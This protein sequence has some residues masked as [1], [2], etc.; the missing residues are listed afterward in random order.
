MVIENTLKQPYLGFLGTGICIIVSLAF[1]T[2]FDA[3]TF[4]TWV[5]LFL[6]SM[7][8]AQMVLGLVWGTSFP[9]AIG[10]MKQPAKGLS[11][12]F[13]MALSGLLVTPAALYLVGGGITPPT[14]Y[15]IMYIILSVV[16]TFWLVTI[17]QCWPLTAI[18][19]HSGVIGVGIWLFSYFVT[20]VLFELLFD[21]SFLKGTPLH[22]DYLDPQGAFNAWVTLSFALTSMVIMLALVLLDFWPVAIIVKKIP[23]LGRQ[24]FFGVLSTVVVLCV[25]YLIWSF[26]VTRQGMDPVVYMVQVPASM[27][28]GQFIMLIML[29]TAPVQ[30]IQQ[31][32][33]GC[34]LLFMS[35]ILSIVMYAFYGIVSYFMVGPLTGGGPEYQLDLW[36]ASAML[37]VTFPLL[38]IYAEFF[39]F[40]PFIGTEKKQNEL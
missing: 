6:V 16:A 18:S 5:T 2:L 37:A 36:L 17:M 1:C 9:P 32:F 21:F 8:P 40:W 12:V 19:R 33:K 30:T 24:P 7:I 34:V 4:T 39:R 38:I 14:P 28:F 31:P 15:V 22:I 35:S 29:Q 13:F 23:S 10:G 3:M 26:F 20:Y 27:I 11:L 25:T